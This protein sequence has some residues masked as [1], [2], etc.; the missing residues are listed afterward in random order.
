MTSGTENRS[1]SAI[2]LL[3]PFDGIR[4]N[5]GLSN[6]HLLD[7]F[8]A[9]P[10]EIG[11]W[12]CLFAILKVIYGCV[13]DLFDDA[14]CKELSHIS[15]LCQEEFVEHN[16]S[17]SKVRNW[18]A[19]QW[20]AFSLSLFKLKPYYIRIGFQK[21]FKHCGARSESKYHTFCVGIHYIVL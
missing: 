2:D 17:R 1:S 13:L 14:N 3:L 20:M 11:L 7:K 12:M 5:G 18:C 19:W 21:W 6:L 8:D 16:I 10:K 15:M 4:L 9:W